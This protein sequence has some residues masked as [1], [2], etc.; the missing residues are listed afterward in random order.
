MPQTTLAVRTDLLIDGKSV[1]TDDYTP[2]HNP[3]APAEI[4]GYTAAATEELARAAVTAAHAAFPGWASAP[5]RT[6][7]DLV[8]AALA[9]LSDTTAER[10]ALLV[11]EN[12]KIAFESDLDVQ[13]CD[14]RTRAAVAL[15]DTLTD[16]P[17]FDG[18]PLTSEVHAMPVA[19]SPSSSRS[20]GPSRSSPRPCPTR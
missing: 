13:F 19:S 2:V 5:A 14:I 12:G 7:A 4:V 11:G 9:S 20:T 15:T 16:V 17:R 1:E 18:P 3:A 10:A 6:R 8:S